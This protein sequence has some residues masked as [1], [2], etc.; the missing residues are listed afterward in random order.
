MARQPETCCRLV[1]VFKRL[2]MT[3]RPIK[4]AQIVGSAA[5]NVHLG[6]SKAIGRSKWTAKG[7]VEEAEFHA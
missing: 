5:V 2:W 3:T 1:R 6:G 7:P 4:H